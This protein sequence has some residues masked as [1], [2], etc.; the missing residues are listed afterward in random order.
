MR[1][2]AATLLCHYDSICCAVSY[3]LQTCLSNLYS[4]CELAGCV[5]SIVMFV[6]GNCCSRG[7]S[8]PARDVKG[9]VCCGQGMASWSQHGESG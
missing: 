9:L 8:S 1:R 4:V 5:C 7:C 3:N 2:A 6:G